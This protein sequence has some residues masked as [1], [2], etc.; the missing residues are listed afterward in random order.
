MNQHDRITLAGGLATLAVIC[1]A[2]V[3]VVWVVQMAPLVPGGSVAGS[4]VLLVLAVFGW[5]ACFTL[6]ND[7]LDRLS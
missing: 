4:V 6:I 2:P 7:V 5:Q 1:L 3:S